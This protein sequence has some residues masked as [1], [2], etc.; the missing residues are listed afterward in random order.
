MNP[1]GV[2]PEQVAAASSNAQATATEIDGQ[3][4]SLRTFVEQEIGPTWLGVS[5][6][7]FQSVM[8]DFQN[9]ARNLHHALTEIG[10]G[11]AGNFEN[12]VD[13]EAQVNANLGGLVSINGGMPPA[14][15]DPIPTGPTTAPGDFTIS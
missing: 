6:T 3:L 1:F 10:D 15:L 4:T 9:Y 8:Q 13:M 11:L 5:A 7:T 2:T 12:Y 14:H